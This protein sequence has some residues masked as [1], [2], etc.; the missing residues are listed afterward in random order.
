MYVHSLEGLGKDI[1]KN[2]H[3]R[4]TWSECKHEGTRQRR[5]DITFKVKF[6]SSF[7]DFRREAE[8]ALARWMTGARARL[9]IEKLEPRL[10]KWHKEISDLNYPDNTPL[11]LIGEM[12]YRGANSTWRVVEV[13]LQAYKLF[14]SAQIES[15]ALLRCF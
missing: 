10:K 4:Q 15:G 5:C 6:R 11:C 12:V 13:L 8:R 14:P 9:L 3:V 7:A 2:G 1:E